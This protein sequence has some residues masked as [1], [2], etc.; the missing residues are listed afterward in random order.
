MIYTSIAVGFLIIAF[1]WWRFTS[2]ARGARQRDEKLLVALDPIV[3]KLSKKESVTAIE[4]ATLSSRPQFRPMLYQMLKHFERLDL[5]PSDC[6]SREAQGAGVLSYWMMHPNELQDAPCEIELVENVERD[7]QG[8]RCEFLVFRYRM[9]PGH[10][11]EKDGWLL[12]LAGPFLEND[13]PYSGVA[14]GFSRIDKH[15]EVNPPDLID[16][17]LGLSTRKSV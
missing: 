2:V 16:W 13:I 15:G 5:F 1:L 14:T 6:L 11:A 3:E 8:E 10:W 12:G 17:Y 9:P 7:V 4:V